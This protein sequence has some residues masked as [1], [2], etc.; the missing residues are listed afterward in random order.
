MIKI[1]RKKNEDSDL[2]GASRIA[3]GHIDYFDGLWVKGWLAHENYAAMEQDVHYRECVIYVNDVQILTFTAD[4]F[5]PDLDVIPELR[6]GR[7]YNI[8]LPAQKIASVI[9]NSDAVEASITVDGEPVKHTRITSLT[10]YY[11]KV[12]S[13]LYDDINCYLSRMPLFTS[14]SIRYLSP[15]QRA[16]L[17]DVLIKSNLYVREHK[18]LA[19]L[20]ARLTLANDEHGKTKEL[21]TTLCYND[22]FLSSFLSACNA[23]LF[24]HE[25]YELVST[26][27][28]T[29]PYLFI[30]ELI[31][32]NIR[33]QATK[34]KLNEIFTQYELKKY[35]FIEKFPSNLIEGVKLWE[36]LSS[37]ERRDYW[38]LLAGSLQFQS[39]F[40]DLKY[41]QFEPSWYLDNPDEHIDRTEQ[42][43]Q[44][45]DAKDNSWFA[46]SFIAYLSVSGQDKTTVANLLKLY[47]WKSW[48][49]DFFDSDTFC[50]VINELLDEKELVSE[51]AYNDICEALDNVIRFKSEKNKNDLLRTP[52][53][54]SVAATINL[55]IKYRYASFY[56]LEESV[57]AYLGMN[58]TFCETLD[59]SALEYFDSNHFDWLTDFYKKSAYVR[60][61]F[62][63][64]EYDKEYSDS[65]IIEVIQKLINLDKHYG[66]LDVQPRILGLSRYCQLMG[67]NSIYAFLKNVHLELGDNYSALT[68]ETDRAEIKNLTRVISESGHNKKR[69]DTYWFKK[70]LN[71]RKDKELEQNKRFVKELIKFLKQSNASGTF[72]NQDLVEL[73][74]SEMIWRVLK[75][76]SLLIV[77]AEIKTIFEAH[78]GEYLVA[79]NMLAATIRSQPHKKNSMDLLDSIQTE[80]GGFSNLNQALDDLGVNI[81]GLE[82][83]IKSGAIHKKIKERFVYPYTCICIYSCR[84]Y[85]DTRHQVLRDT[86]INDLKQYDID[87][88]IVVGGEAKSKIDGDLMCLEVEDTYEAL[89]YKSI[90]MFEFAAKQFKHQYFYKIDDDCILNVN[91]MFSDPAFL[92]TEY[93][94]RVVSRPLGGVDR[95][96]HHLKSTSQEAKDA[97]DLSPELSVYCDGSTGYILS[98]DAVTKLTE[99]VDDPSNI[100]LITSSYFEDKLV[101][102]LLAVANIRISEA[103]Y[104]CVIRRS[105]AAGRDVQ[106]WS[107][108]LLPNENVNIKVVHTESDEFRRAFYADLHGSKPVI[109]NLI[110]RDASENM[111][112][113]WVSGEQQA[114]V[115]EKLSV[116]LDAIKNAR[117]LAII[118]GKNEQIFLPPLLKHHR[119][120][121]VDHFLFVD[122]GSS[123]SSIEYMQKQDDVSI[124]IASQDYKFSRFGVNWQ[125]TLLSHYCLGKWTLIIDSDELFVYDDFENRSIQD[126]QMILD[127]NGE[128]AVLSPMVDFYPEGELSS[129]DISSGE[130]LYKICN[131]FDSVASMNV[132]DDTRYGPFSNSKVYSAGLRERIFG[133]YNPYPEP[134]YLNQKYNMVKYNPGMKLIEGLHFM[135]GH[136]L[137][138]KQCGIM[139]FKYHSGFHDKVK[140]E[141]KEGQHWN[142]AKEYQRYLGLI[143]KKKNFSMFDKKY[144]RKYISS[145]D[146]IDQGYMSSINWA[147][148]EKNVFV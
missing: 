98:R 117:T 138:T 1:S 113:E 122:N 4:E 124:F 12:F 110:Y 109:P 8:Q 63:D 30:V 5:R 105:I 14:K 121:G 29:K 50:M 46:L 106:I 47:A 6:H 71:A 114:P 40:Q 57:R 2:N 9:A 144:S 65:E 24:D 28:R 3:K 16:Y 44:A 19:N 38:P 51:H 147:L 99:V 53:I 69:A 137:S 139:H 131:H 125:E 93:F 78:A 133:R 140:R 10:D 90:R 142:G 76:G 72:I 94:G 89:P 127:S 135:A 66:V 77:D 7:G 96:W 45:V 59:L 132:L 88:K 141:V 21:I 41:I 70:A 26:I 49:L 74:V 61:F 80:M 85:T 87:Y 17:I 18:L 136:K 22:V 39:R 103:G 36:K 33:D 27:I 123:D 79:L 104:N 92:K 60:A 11:F 146:L 52:F 20:C 37:R 73:A 34:N 35:A 100:Q 115:L 97:L 84:K 83:A 145:K 134:N 58:N 56:K 116:D 95:A 64:F 86:W 67:K 107:Y 48:H 25:L 23:Q 108:G 143:T 120:I 75:G 102:D 91:A 111:Q 68:M 130:S 54:S 42:I 101:G 119:Q 129:A 55:G 148:F 13:G 118:V 43:R 82:S 62:E 31:E 32:S 126:L 112:P 15:W 81:S 128:N